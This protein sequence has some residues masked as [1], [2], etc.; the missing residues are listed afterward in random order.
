MVIG[1]GGVEGGVISCVYGWWAGK[2]GS[3]II[4]HFM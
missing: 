1:G 2:Y 3:K 4:R